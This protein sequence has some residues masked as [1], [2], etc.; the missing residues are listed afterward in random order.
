MTENN[1]L[2]ETA[3]EKLKATVQPFQKELSQQQKKAEFIQQC[4]RFAS[5]DDFLKLDEH[6]RTKTALEIIEDE[7]LAE[8]AATFDTLKVYAS[9]KV[10][11]Y[12]LEFIED[13]TQ[14]CK[15]AGFEITIDSNRFFAL[16]GVSGEFDFATRTTTINKK[17]LKSID[18]RRIV[19]AIQQQKRL[20]YDSPYDP[21]KFI[22][23]LF[24]TYK[25]MLKQNKG[26]IGD[27]LPIQ[28]FYV[29]HVIAL[30][31][32]TF[33]LNMDKAKFKGYSID[34]FSVD[35]WRYYE[36]DIG[37]TSDGYRLDLTGGRN[38]AL[39]LLDSNGETKQMSSISFEI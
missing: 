4:I 21:Q 30:Q 32:K 36:S 29:A 27:K 37:G 23:T 5:Q 24:S 38:K 1:N 11:S 10:E 12:R 18:P 13:L 15:E 39:W 22:D 26:N 35:L 25:E 2:L 31:N 34:Q 14:L 9:E 20:L 17:A 6:L 16:K 7:K 3:Q 33:L 19:T 8:C 28:D